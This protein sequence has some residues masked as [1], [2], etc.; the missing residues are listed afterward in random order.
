MEAVISA[1]TA[2]AG[3]AVMHLPPITVL[4]FATRSG[5]VISRVPCRPGVLRV[6]RALDNDV[7]I[8]DPFI[9]ATHLQIDIDVQGSVCVTDAG[10]VNGLFDGVGRNARR[11]P[12]LTLAIDTPVKFGHSTLRLRDVRGAVEPERPESGT[13][14]GGPLFGARVATLLVVA[15]ALWSLVEAWFTNFAVLKPA[16]LLLATSGILTSFF[17]WVGAWALVTRVFT[18]HARFAAHAAVAGWAVLAWT[19]LQIILHAAGFS[20]STGLFATLQPVLGALLAMWALLRHLRLAQVRWPR[21][22]MPLAGVLSALSLAVIAF[23]NWDAERS[24]LPLGTPPFADPAFKAVRS[25]PAASFVQEARQLREKLEP[26]RTLDEEG[27]GE[28]DD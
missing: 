1:P 19:A 3:G 9:A 6:G 27:E 26:L 22:N 24:L 11:V 14:L 17:V 8:D 15:I 16:Q 21:L 10:S 20:F 18:G 23:N 25:I 28:L 12:R 7:V 5:H 4:E 2:P 13:Q